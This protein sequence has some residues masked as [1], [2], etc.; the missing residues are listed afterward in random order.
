MIP[1]VDDDSLPRLLDAAARPVLV[2]FWSPRCAPCAALARELERL[3]AELGERL[4][5]LGVNVDENPRTRGL[6]EIERLPALGL[7][8]SGELI[9]FIGGMGRKDAIQAAVEAALGAPL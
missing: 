9:G 3:A 7:F 2:D 6:Y 4:V 5:I 1:Q 8:R